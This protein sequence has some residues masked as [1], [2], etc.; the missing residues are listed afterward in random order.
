MRGN[1]KGDVDGE[2]NGGGEGKIDGDGDGKG[3]DTGDIDGDGNGEGEGKI[4]GDGKG[5]GIGSP[6]CRT[7]RGASGLCTE[8]IVEGKLGGAVGCGSWAFL[9]S[10]RFGR[11]PSGAPATGPRLPSWVRP[12]GKGLRPP[13]ASPNGVS[14]PMSREEQTSTAIHFDIA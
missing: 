3:E 7:V 9:T 6:T 13:F 10:S 12:L 8:R 14:V 1:S 11:D 5:E 4:E 2:G